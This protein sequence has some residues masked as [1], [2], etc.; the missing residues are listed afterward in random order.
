[1][2]GPDAKCKKGCL[3]EA[4]RLRMDLANAQQ[5]G[6][7]QKQKLDSQMNSLQQSLDH[8]RAQNSALENRY[9]LKHHSLNPVSWPRRCCLA[10]MAGFAYVHNCAAM[11]SSDHAQ[12]LMHTIAFHHY[13]CS[14]Q[15][16]TQSGIHMH[17]PRASAASMCCW[18]CSIKA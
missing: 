17:A 5:H 11:S 14:H 1:M 15:H 18:S 8:A 10:E 7:Q 4:D 16:Q 2:K 6:D 12:F 13:I 3:Q 9:S